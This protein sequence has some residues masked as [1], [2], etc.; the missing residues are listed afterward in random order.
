MPFSQINFG[1]KNKQCT[2]TFNKEKKILQNIA[3]LEIFGMEYFAQPGTPMRTPF[4]Y[5]D[6]TTTQTP[7]S[8]H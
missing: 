4:G 5:F 7:T 8:F 2:L 6:L 1:I 3:P